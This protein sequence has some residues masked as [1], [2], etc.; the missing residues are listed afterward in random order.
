[1]FHAAQRCHVAEGPASSLLLQG[2]ASFHSRWIAVSGPCVNSFWGFRHSTPF[3]FIPVLGNPGMASIMRNRWNS[4]LPRSGLTSCVSQG[5]VT[6]SERPRRRWQRPGQ[7][8]PDRG[9]PGRS[10]RKSEPPNERQLIP[11]GP[12]SAAITSRWLERSGRWGSRGSGHRRSGVGRRLGHQV[13]TGAA[14]IT[15]EQTVVL[16]RRCSLQAGRLGG[17]RHNHQYRIEEVREHEP[18]HAG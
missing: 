6:P 7:T 2:H 1:M 8:R 4:P 3:Q 15:G 12:R 5:V 17:F 14:W 18:A 13:S 9:A 16:R 11:W 10:I